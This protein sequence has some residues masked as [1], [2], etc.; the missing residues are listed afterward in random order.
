MNTSTRAKMVKLSDVVNIQ[1]GYPFRSRVEYT[2]TGDV[3]VIQIG[4]I[5]EG[6]SIAYPHLKRV[7]GIEPGTHYFVQQ[8][9]VLLV[10]RGDQQ[11]AMWVSEPLPNTIAVSNFFIL[12]I[13]T[14]QI[15]PVYLMWYL[16]SQPAQQFF[17]VH[18]L[19]T[20]IRSL[21]KSDVA[22]MTLPVPSLDIQ[23]K[24]GQAYLLMLKEQHVFTQ[25]Q[26]KRQALIEARL[27][28]AVYGA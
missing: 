13:Q 7:S 18:K 6:D 20:N 12:R 16:N 10:A 4:D 22:E 11:R 26:H 25:L 1:S 15:R 9:D 8:N 14:D 17:E 3:A 2:T 19:G 5:D 24:I 27:L 23:E 21:H 28:K